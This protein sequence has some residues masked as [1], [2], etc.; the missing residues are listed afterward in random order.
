VK[1][2]I[3][4]FDIETATAGPKPNPE[5]D[6]FRIFG[7]YSYKYKKYYFEKDITKVQQIINEHKFLV[8][9]NSSDP[10]S[11][12]DVPILVRH[13]IDFKKKIQLDTMTIMGKRSQ[14]MGISLKSKSLRYLAEVFKLEI[15]K[16]NLD[17][18]ILKKP[19][20]MWSESE[21]KEI[22]E[23]L[24]NDVDITRQVFEKI[25]DFYE[26]FKQFLSPYDQ[27]RL[28]WVSTSIANLGY[29]SMCYKLNLTPEYGNEERKEE[30]GGIVRD[31][32]GETFKKFWYV[33]VTSLY[34]AIIIMFNM[35]SNPTITPN[36]TRWFMGNDIF[37]IKGKYGLS[38]YNVMS[39]Q[40]KTMF[41]Q[42]KPLKKTDPKKAYAYK[43][44][45]NSGYGVLRSPTFKSTFYEHTGADIC[46]IG[47]QI[48]HIMGDFFERDGFSLIYG[49]TDSLML[50]DNSNRPKEEQRKIV[51]K[52]I[53]YIID[54]IKKNVPFPFDGFNIDIETDDMI[55]YI[56]FFYDESTKKFKKKNYLM[57]Y[58]NQI[59]IKGLP[60][61]KDNSTKLGMLI[62][63][64]YLEKRI[65][66]RLDC[67]FDKKEIE[68]YIRK[69]L[70]NDITLSSVSW[71]VNPMESYKNLN[72]I[73]AQI[74]KMYLDGERGR[75]RLIKNTRIGRVGKGN[76]YC[77]VEESKSLRYEDLILD[78]VWNELEPFI[79]E[80]KSIDI[81]SFVND[82]VEE[83][84]DDMWFEKKKID[85]PM[86]D[87]TFKKWW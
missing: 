63:E 36:E 12:Y 62:Y 32:M 58:G 77:S 9:H 7:G 1:E 31:P 79:K 60:I 84:N 74:S 75:I 80:E 86:D 49:D 81:M 27:E 13:G 61:K 4:V 45:S 67:K 11:A 25:Y 71:N 55:D 33:D 43:I 30:I 16:G 21:E 38:Q 51:E 23:Y 56:C 3:I 68:G 47:Q 65:I 42:R 66:E 10:E 41:L 64:K 52:N 26:V 22:I 28:V 5:K 85:K 34:P 8:G 78:K 20:Y 19:S 40:F 87:F 44:L 29:L 76:R 54:F 48:N 35:I 82:D 83:K 69:E 46:R 53:G 18:G 72:Q 17:Y 24:K 50:K 14:T 39:E 37:K 73:Q 70:E 15:R 6:E 59:D 2:N 57:V